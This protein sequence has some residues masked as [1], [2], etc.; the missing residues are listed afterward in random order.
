MCQQIISWHKYSF[1]NKLLAYLE[2][3]W[4]D[5]A[6]LAILW[7]FYCVVHSVLAD[8]RVKA[9]FSGRMGKSF[10]YY[11]LIYTLISFAG[12]VIILW[13]QVS[14]D[15][16]FIYTSNI[17]TNVVGTVTGLAGLLIMLYCIRKYFMS[18]SGF[19]TLIHNDEVQEG[20]ELYIAGLHRYVRHP[21]YLGTFLFIWGVWVVVPTLSLLI[22]NAIIT[23]YTLIAIPLEERKLLKEFGASY[24]KYSETVP[25]IIPRFR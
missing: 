4:K 7:M 22:A 17:I 9:Y 19:R 15:T 8:L 14:I 6:I 16:I 5:H 25:R 23:I 10:I 12:L 20:N 11:R 21:L 3:M 2:F 13:Y 1:T 18:L 24:K